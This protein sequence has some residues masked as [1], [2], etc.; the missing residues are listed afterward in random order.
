VESSAEKDR[1]HTMCCRFTGQCFDSLD[2]VRPRCR[3][4]QH[5]KFVFGE[6]HR[7]RAY[8]QAFLAHLLHRRVQPVATMQFSIIPV[9]PYQ[10][11]CSLVWCKHT[12]KA[13]L[14]D[15]GGEEDR[16][17]KAV[18]LAGVKLDMLLL[19]HGHL[20]HVGAAKKLSAQW[21]IPILGPH[22]EDAFLLDSLPEQA[23]RFGFPPAQAFTPDRWLEDGEQIKLGEQRFEVLHCPGHTPGHLV[24]YNPTARLAFVGDVLFQ[25]SIGRT[26]FPRGNLADLIRS[27][28]E[29]LFPLG[30]DI[31]FVPGHGPMST[32]G[33]ERLHNPFVGDMR[34]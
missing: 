1:R 20:D 27:I 3:A 29:T 26:D 25:G 5:G 30:D 12:G 18:A 10:Q 28:R 6:K 17:L 34:R 23:Q 8:H 2:D 33:D 7:L 32:L 15:P 31:A 9:T 11:N 24:F 19:T 22:R 4:K 16:L 13:A 21:G 14:I